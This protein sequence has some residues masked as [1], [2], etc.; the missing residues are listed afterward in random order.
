MSFLDSLSS[1]VENVKSKLT[2]IS[3]PVTNAVQ[4]ALPEIA[5]DEGAQKLLGTPSENYTTMGGGKR[6]RTRRRHRRR[7]TR[8]RRG[9]GNCPVKC[10]KSRDGKHDFSAFVDLGDVKERS[11][12]NCKC[13]QSV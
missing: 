3:R 13:V 7:H 9:G 2:S 8:R 10:E 5:T 12:K 6:R 11:C 1:V 4:T